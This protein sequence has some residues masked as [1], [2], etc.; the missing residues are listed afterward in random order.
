MNLETVF[1]NDDITEI[2]NEMILYS[3]LKYQSLTTT[4]Q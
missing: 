4:W 2:Y 3:I 1:T